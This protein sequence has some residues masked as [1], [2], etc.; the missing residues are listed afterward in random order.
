MNRPRRD[1]A[2]HPMERP[3]PPAAGGGPRSTHLPVQSHVS[4]SPVVTT[5]ARHTHSV[6][7][8]R[9]QCTSIALPARPTRHSRAPSSSSTTHPRSLQSPL[10]RRRWRTAYPSATRGENVNYA[11]V[12]EARL[13]ARDAAAARAECCGRPLRRGRKCG[14][15]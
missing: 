3:H 5:T 1:L 11:G 15:Q 6:H 14:P 13:W 10:P 4:A 8:I 7:P 9:Q 12:G 2:C